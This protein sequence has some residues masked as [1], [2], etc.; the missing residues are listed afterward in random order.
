MITAFL[1]LLFS[2]PVL[3]MHAAK[4]SLHT[5]AVKKLGY[6]VCNA[7]GLVCVLFNS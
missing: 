3:Y 5:P 1:I 2:I 6:D 4:P 7:V